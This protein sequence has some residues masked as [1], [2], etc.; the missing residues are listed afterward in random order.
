[1]AVIAPVRPAAQQAR[2][3]TL[4]ELRAFVGP[5]NDWQKPFDAYIARTMIQSGFP[6]RNPADQEIY[7]D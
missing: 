3:K 1:M 6:L 7:S 4:T 2:D 5:H